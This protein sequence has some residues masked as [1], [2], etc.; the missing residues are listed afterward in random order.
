AVTPYLASLP[1]TPATRCKEGAYSLLNNYNPGYF[2]DG[3]VNTST[4][5]IPPSSVPT[6]GDTMNAAGLS[7]KYYGAG[8]DNYVQDPNSELGSTYCNICNPFLYETA[9]M[10]SAAQRQ[11]H[12]ADRPDLDTDIANGPLPAVSIVKPD[13]LLD[14]HPASSILSDFEAFTK[15]IIQEVQAHPDLWAHT[16]IL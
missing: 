2:G 4:F 1:Y 9:I 13:G 14:W 12:L 7:W 11:A 16:A 5:T 15:K 8:W 6:I 10:T 3:T